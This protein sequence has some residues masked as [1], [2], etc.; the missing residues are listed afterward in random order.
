MSKI[1]EEYLKTAN[2]NSVLIKRKLSKY[3]KHTDINNEFEYWLENK[4]Y[5]SENPVTVCGYTAKDISKLSPYLDGE[6]AFNM[7]IGLRENP[8][9]TKQQLNAEFKIK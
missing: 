3:Q 9:R 8:E 2:T 6:G 5:I 4:S 7:L 1:I